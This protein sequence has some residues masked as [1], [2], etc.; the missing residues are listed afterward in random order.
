M[1]INNLEYPYQSFIQLFIQNLLNQPL[2]LVNGI[3]GYA[4]HD[5]SLNNY[6]TIKNRIKELT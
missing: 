6:Q 4:L 1:D 3:I 5:V 2:T